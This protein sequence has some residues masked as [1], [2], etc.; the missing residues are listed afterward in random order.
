MKIIS[1]LEKNKDKDNLYL[2]KTIDFNDK[3]INCSKSALTIDK[4]Y[5][6]K[7]FDNNYAHHLINEIYN[8]TNDL[9]AQQ[10]IEKSKLLRYV[11]KNNLDNT[12]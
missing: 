5:L 2:S 7:K 6:H 1:F 9:I 12:N 8:V 10:D 11:T 4:E 3:M